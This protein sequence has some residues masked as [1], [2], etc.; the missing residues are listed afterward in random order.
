MIH[1]FFVPAFR[2]KM[3]V[4]PAGTRPPV[5]GD[6]ARL[7]RPLLHEYCGTGHSDMRTQVVVHEA[8]MFEKWLTEASDFLAVMSPEDGGKRLY[9]VRGCKQCTRW[10]ARADRPHVQECV[11]RQ[12]VTTAGERV[13]VDENYIR[14]SILQPQAKIVPVSSR[15]CR[16]T[17]AG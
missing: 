10:M 6:G 3:D 17:R 7:L 13:V 9:E 5:R 12:E 8:G 1:S 11:G 15:S 14:E 2:V 4:V 16:R